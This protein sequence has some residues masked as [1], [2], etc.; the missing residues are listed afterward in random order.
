MARIRRASLLGLAVIRLLA[1]TTACVRRV[2]SGTAPAPTATAPAPTVAVPSPTT[3]SPSIVQATLTAPGSPAFRLRAIIA[4]RGDP[5]SKT[6]VEISWMAPDKWRRT[7]QSQTEFSQTLIVNGDKVYEQDSDS[8]FPLWS[9]TLVTAMVDPRPV[10][11]AFRPGDRLMTKANGASDESGRM[12]FPD[13]PRMCMG[14]SFGLQEVVGA[15]GH[16]VDFLNYQDFEGKRV[17]RILIYHVDPG[18][19]YKAQVTE[20]T[21]LKNPDP[22]LFTIGGEATSNSQQIRSFVLPEAELRSQILGPTEITWPQVLD[23]AITGETSFYVSVD[24]SGRVRETLPLSMANERANDSARRQIMKWKFKPV[25]KDG[26]PVQVEAV[27][28][29][30]FNTRAYGPA[31]PLTDAACGS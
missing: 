29:F 7:I 30:H 27:L 9:Q 16:S 22:N 21:E 26:I 13:N 31:S 28:N 19:S 8:Y 2:R 3:P 5:T 24:R 15:A 14:G 11:D 12:C 23:G 18:D 10:L 6:D 17:A 4:E 25:V 20:L 1:G